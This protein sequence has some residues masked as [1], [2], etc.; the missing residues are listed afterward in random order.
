[1]LSSESEEEPKPPL[2]FMGKGRRGREDP[3]V[4]TGASRWDVGPP[5]WGV[6]LELEVRGLGPLVGLVL[7]EKWTWE[8][9]GPSGEALRGSEGLRGNAFIK[10]VRF[11]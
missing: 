6:A 5:V 10:F 9:V 7:A 4:R 2:L 8:G 1:M 3:A 11:L